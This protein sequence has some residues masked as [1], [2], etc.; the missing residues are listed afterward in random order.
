MS[1]NVKL[2]S[3]FLDVDAKKSSVIRIQHPV[4]ISVKVF[5]MRCQTRIRG[6]KQTNKQPNNKQFFLHD[7][8]QQSIDFA[9]PAPIK[10][11]G[12]LK[13]P[14]LKKKAVLFLDEADHSSRRYS[15][16]ILQQHWIK[17]N[18]NLEFNYYINF[19]L[20]TLFFWK[21]GII[22]ESGQISWRFLD[23][24]T[25]QRWNICPFWWDP[26]RQPSTS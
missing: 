17:V 1:I 20:M 8:H 25:W 4:I 15:I 18:L 9:S 13:L 26:C 10:K 22:A 14:F 23:P 21:K 24:A 12:N 19:G 5:R 6:D 16:K 11:Y 2:T 7:S 3:M